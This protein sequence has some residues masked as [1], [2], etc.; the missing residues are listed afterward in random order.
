MAKKILLLF[1]CWFAVLMAYGQEIITRTDGVAIQAQVLEIKPNQINFRLFGQPDTL[2]Y[3]ISTQDVQTLRRA[4]GATQTFNQPGANVADRGFNY[5]TQTRR[6][7]L[8][9]HPLD[10]IYASF[11]LGYEYLL[12]SGK[13][14]VKIP[15]S[16]GLAGGTGSNYYDDFRRN[17]R[18]GAGLELNIYPFG[19]GRFN[20]Y[21]GPAVNY[22]SYRFYYYNYAQGL[23]Q[24]E[25]LKENAQLFTAA[26]KNGIYYQFNKSFSIGADVGLGIRFFNEPEPTVDYYYPENRTR[27]FLPGNLQLGFRF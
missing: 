22:R 11:T 4:D 1:Y 20:Y 5:E 26:I 7:I 17:N 24:P 14:G 15:V 27:G 6:H 13:L 23:P 16:L 19:Q 9:F 18:Y 3:Q 2:I 25:L 8:W 12:P 21:F 10:L